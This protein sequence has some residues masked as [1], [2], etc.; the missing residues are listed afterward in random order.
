MTSGQPVPT[1]GFV[2]VD[3]SSLRD[4]IAAFADS[5]NQAS[6]LDVVRATLQGQLLL[7]ATGSDRP[8]IAPDGG[9]S[10]PAGS[11]L[12]FAGGTGPDDA[13]A[14]FAF[15]SQEQ[16]LKMHPDNPS[17]VQSIVQ[18][19]AAALHLATTE[20][21]GWIYIDPAGPTCAISSRDASFA[22]AGER[23]DSVKAALE[24][25]DPDARTTAVM[26]AL[27][28]NGPLLLAVDTD[29][30]PEDGVVGDEPV[31]I[32]SSVNADGQ[33][34]LL[35]FTSGPEV[36]ALNVGDSFAARAAKEI[37]REAME[38]PYFGLVINPGGPWAALTVDHL[39][40]VLARTAD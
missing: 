7:D 35:A 21:Y 23:N 4:A 22:L 26:T 25:V 9:V 24:I 29:S 33:A 10:F 30:V 1:G 13:P 40:E 27:T 20:R 19:A 12:Q 3:N 15:T 18:P 14:L 34:V 31:R 5:P 8:T 17:E 32:R 38:E 6:Y 37:M 2:P 36:S 39:R 11:M 16:I 28:E